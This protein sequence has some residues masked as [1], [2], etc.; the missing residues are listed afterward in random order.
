MSVLEV[1]SEVVWKDVL[2]VNELVMVD[3]FAAWCGPCKAI[4]PKVS[5][6]AQEFREIQFTKVDI[7]K[8][9]SFA[10]KYDVRQLPTFLFFQAGQ[11]DRK[12][13][14]VGASPVLLQARLVSLLAKLDQPK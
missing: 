13:R 1:D 12:L 8:F 3:C 2:D 14:L 5:S 6:L 11:E 4:A 7:D 10:E 9:Q